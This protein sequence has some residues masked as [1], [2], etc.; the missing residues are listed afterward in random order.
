MANDHMNTLRLQLARAVDN[1]AEH[2]VAGYR[3]QH[4]GQRRAHA[5]TLAG[6]EDNDIE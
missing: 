6:G 5:G 3:V 4:L 1:M 2:G